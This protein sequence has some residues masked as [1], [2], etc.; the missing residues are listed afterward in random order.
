MLQAQQW[1]IRESKLRAQTPPSLLAGFLCGFYLL[2]LQWGGKWGAASFPA[3][4]SMGQPEGKLRLEKG[5]EGCF[6]GSEHQQ[7]WSLP[8]VQAEIKKAH[9]RR[10]LALDFKQKARASSAAGS[11]CYGG[12]MSHG[13]TSFSVSLTGRGPGGTQPRGLLL[14]ARGSL[15]G[16]TP[17]SCAADL[18]PHLTQ[19]MSQKTCGENTVGSKDPDESHPNPNKELE[20]M[21][22]SQHCISQLDWSF[23]FWATFVLAWRA[24][25]GDSSWINSLPFF[26]QPACQGTTC[27]CSF[28][29]LPSLKMSSSS[30]PHFLPHAGDRFKWCLHAKPWIITGNSPPGS[31]PYCDGL[32][33]DFSS[34]AYKAEPM[35]L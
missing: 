22:W 7:L 32:E 6:A 34:I 13:T 30:K 20:T 8:Q 10:S 12:L 18:L 27:S 2:L 24:G 4:L 1:L 28:L 23:V 17:S 33:I 14:S 35:R 19:E 25:V 29:Y 21:L 11:C 9:F 31:M 16:Y 26:S 5:K 15:P 3:P